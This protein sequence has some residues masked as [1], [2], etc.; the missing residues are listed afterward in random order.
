MK[1]VATFEAEPVC[2]LG[3]AASAGRSIL[4][5]VPIWPFH[6]LLNYQDH[7]IKLYNNCLLKSKRF[8]ALALALVDIYTIIGAPAIL[9]SNSRHEF[10]GQAGKGLGLSEEEIDG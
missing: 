7:E 6:V 5:T 8:A 9:Q 1:V 4:L 3:C 10:V 2:F